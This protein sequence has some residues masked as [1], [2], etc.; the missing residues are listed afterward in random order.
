MSD[1]DPSLVNEFNLAAVLGR[2][3]EHEKS[4]AAYREILTR[5][6]EEHGPTATPHFIAVAKM[7]A[8]FCLM[9]LERYEEAE[10]EFEGVTPLVY[11]LPI[12]DRYEFYFAYGNTLGRLGK[13]QPMFNELINAVSCSEDMED[14]TQKPEAC[15]MQILLHAERAQSWAFLKE[16]AAI[17]LNNARLRG[18]TRLARFAG[19]MLDKAQRAT[20]TLN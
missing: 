4:L 3:G 18:M 12:A 2:M 7:R 17:A 9:D 19:S 6:S 20:S 11:F 15:W 14:Y 13:L 5:T 1:V 8:A 10:R 16:K